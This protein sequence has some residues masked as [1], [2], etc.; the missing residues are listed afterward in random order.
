MPGGHPRGTGGT[1]GDIRERPSGVT[2]RGAPGGDRRGAG[3]AAEA[4]AGCRGED[5][6]RPWQS[7]SGE[8]EGATGEVPPER[9]GGS[10][11]KRGGGTGGDSDV[12]VEVFRAAPE[13]PRGRSEESRE[14]GRQPG[15]GPGRAEDLGERQRDTGENTEASWW[16]HCRDSGELCGTQGGC[17]RKHW[18][19]T[20]KNSGRG[21]EGGRG[22]PRKHGQRKQW[23]PLEGIQGSTQGALFGG[24][25]PR[26]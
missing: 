11:E 2:G 24:G 3:G 8:L 1:W 4:R 21:T 5:R 16:G 22:P 23:G 13:G 6:G 14:S 17:P 15:V 19:G 26:G 12:G 20:G 25:T 18:H 7:C 10:R 9:W